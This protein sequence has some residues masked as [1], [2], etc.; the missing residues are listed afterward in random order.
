MLNKDF[1]SIRNKGTNVNYEEEFS[2]FNGHHNIYLGSNIFLVDTLID[3]GNKE[4]TVKIND[5]VFFGHGVKILARRHDYR[6]LNQDR[7]AKVVE[8]PIHIQREA[9]VSSGS[10][11]LG[12]VTIG[13]NTVVGTGSVATKDVAEKAIVVGNPA[14]IIKYI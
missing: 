1:K 9:W 2:V 11:I 6:L 3:A 5:Y 4:G 12:G 13:K 14:K 10:I 8:K 7:Q